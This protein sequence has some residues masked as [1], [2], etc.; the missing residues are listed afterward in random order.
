MK[1]L[2][3]SPAISCRINYMDPSIYLIPC[4]RI[5]WVRTI[6]SIG[7]ASFVVGVTR[8]STRNGSSGREGKDLR[9]PVRIVICLPNG[10]S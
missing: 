8:G 1:G 4:P 7:R 9:R 3:V 2:P 10:E 6:P 5:Q